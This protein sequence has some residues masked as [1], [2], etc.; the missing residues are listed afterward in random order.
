MKCFDTSFELWRG[1]FYLRIRM[2]AARHFLASLW[3]MALKPWKEE[4]IFI[5]RLKRNLW[6]TKHR[7]FPREWHGKN[8]AAA[9]GL[10]G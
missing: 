10:I 2:A 5:R 3:S 1:V 6:N 9:L 7:K 4:T 8:N